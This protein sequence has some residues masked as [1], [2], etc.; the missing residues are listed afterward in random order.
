ML[1]RKDELIL[2]DSSD[3]EEEDFQNLHQKRQKPIQGIEDAYGI[4]DALETQ[5]KKISNVVDGMD[6]R[7]GQ[8]LRCLGTVI[9]PE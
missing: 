5:L 7:M 1:F 2:P 9:S 4:V 6:K 8:N 3:E